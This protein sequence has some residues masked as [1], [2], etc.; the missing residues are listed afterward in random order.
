MIVIFLGPTLPI[1]EAQRILPEATYLPP[2]SQ[3][4]I[5]K[6]VLHRPHVMGIIDGYFEHV[7][8][9]WHKEILW[10]MKQGIHVFGASSMGALR[11]AELAAF[12]MVGIGKIYEAYVSGEIEDDDEVA[13]AHAPAEEGYLALS[14]AMV[15]MR[16]TLKK[17][18]QQG[19]LTSRSA[20]EKIAK[21]LFY[22]ERTYPALL[23][24][25]AQQNLPD[26]EALKMWLPQNQ[27][28]QKQEDAVLL[29]HTLKEKL[30]HL[31]APK[32]VLYTFQ[33]TQI[34]ERA[35]RQAADSPQIL[36][37]AF[38]RASTR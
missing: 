26:G 3:G 20:L 8:S 1:Q 5:L 21:D 36:P 27:V 24:I 29:L 2:V 17:A 7:P 22:P 15:D 28:H 16:A 18:E 34:W 25:A 4:D 32:R 13:V 6:A 9:V 37:D 12:G 11:A 19:L 30:A 14:T 33:P 38:A 31:N 35:A 23:K 10:A